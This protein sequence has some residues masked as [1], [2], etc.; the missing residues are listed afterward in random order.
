MVPGRCGITQSSQA[1]IMMRKHARYM[2]RSLRR[3]DRMGNLA[4]ALALPVR[5]CVDPS[6]NDTTALMTRYS[7]AAYRT[8][9]T[10]RTAASAGPAIWR[11]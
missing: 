2:P 6:Q 8:I 1:A 9:L 11:D 4:G 7:A 10:T 5:P 3:I